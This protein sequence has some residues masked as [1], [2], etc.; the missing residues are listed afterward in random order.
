MLFSEIQDI[1]LIPVKDAINITWSSPNLANGNLLKTIVQFSNSLDDHIYEIMLS[2]DT[3]SLI[4]PLQLNSQFYNFTIFGIY[5]VDMKVREG[6]HR[7]IMYIVDSMMQENNCSSSD[8]GDIQSEGINPQKSDSTS[9][10]LVTAVSAL[11]ALAL[12]ML[13]IIV[14]LIYN[15]RKIKSKLAFTPSDPPIQLSQLRHV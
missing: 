10:F 8:A 7:S 3:N 6:L 12:L 5:V 1:L 9:A 14:I 4:L 11:S 15:I 2:S 13:I